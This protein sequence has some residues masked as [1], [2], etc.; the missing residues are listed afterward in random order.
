MRTGVLEPSPFL[1]IRE[2]LKQFFLLLLQ[3]KK[4]DLLQ[5]KQDA[6]KAIAVT[7]L[8]DGVMKK[9]LFENLEKLRMPIYQLV[10]FQLEDG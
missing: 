10:S 4:T 9:R 5:K 2:P 7:P 3:S 8:Y 6:K 1:P